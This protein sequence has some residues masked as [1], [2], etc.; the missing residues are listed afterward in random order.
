MKN[1]RAQISEGLTWVV[2]TIAIIV[3]LLISL[4]ITTLAFDLNNTKIKSE[5]FGSALMQKSLMS[6]LLTKESG[7]G[8]VYSEIKRDENLKGF[9]GDLAVK[10]FKG[11]Y[12]KEYS[13]I[14][15]GVSNLGFNLIGGREGNNFFSRM[16]LISTEYY[17]IM[18]KF[19]EEK[20]VEVVFAK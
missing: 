4:A 17:L 9:N 11:L 1:K 13:G 5:S 19:A 12:G 7:R 16:S 18:I 20:A 15:V 6:Y 3:I 14:W 10:V 2:A 8:T